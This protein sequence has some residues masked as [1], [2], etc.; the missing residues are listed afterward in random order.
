MEGLEILLMKLSRLMYLDKV[1]RPCC[2][3]QSGVDNS[4]RCDGEVGRR[5]QGGQ[6]LPQNW[7]R[8]SWSIIDDEYKALVSV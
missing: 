1:S 2:R 7:I 6:Q 4:P 3:C 8:R 5:R